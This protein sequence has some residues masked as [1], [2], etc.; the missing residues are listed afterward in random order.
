MSENKIINKISDII[1]VLN[2]EID[3]KQKESSDI[4]EDTQNYLITQSYCYGL[5]KVIIMLENI[6]NESE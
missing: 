6:L 2:D 4:F 3:I 5:Q 1:I